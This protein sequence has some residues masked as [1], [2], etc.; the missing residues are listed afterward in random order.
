MPQNQAIPFK[1][2]QPTTYYVSRGTDI[3][4]KLFMRD[5]QLAVTL[6]FTSSQQCCCRALINGVGGKLTGMLYHRGESLG[7]TLQA[8]LS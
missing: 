1:M 6:L 3:E 7:D 8:G 4:S 5:L 2:S